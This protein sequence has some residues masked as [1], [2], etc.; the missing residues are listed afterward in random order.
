LDKGFSNGNPTWTEDRAWTGAQLER[1]CDALPAEVEV[2]VR[3]QHL[4]DPAIC[5]AALDDENSQRVIHFALLKVF[6]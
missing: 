5:V 6:R 1:R 2:V 3:E 4:R